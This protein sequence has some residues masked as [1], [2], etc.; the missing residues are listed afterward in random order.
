MSE[1]LVGSP[2]L[3]LQDFPQI[4]SLRPLRL[5]RELY[6]ETVSPLQPEEQIDRDNPFIYTPLKVRSCIFRAELPNQFILAQFQHKKLKPK[7][8]QETIWVQGTVSQVIVNLRNPFPFEIFVESMMLR[9]D[10]LCT[11]HNISRTHTHTHTHFGLAAP[12]LLIKGIR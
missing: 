11:Q 4:L 6:P 3:E 12:V 10:L 5:D 7:T 1:Y 2:S 9:Y 8:A